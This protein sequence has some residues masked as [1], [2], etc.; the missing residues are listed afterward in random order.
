M[1]STDHHGIQFS[2][3][4]TNNCCVFFGSHIGYSW[5]CSIQTKKS[6]N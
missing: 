4:T 3:N 2:E 5:C 1:S 6:L